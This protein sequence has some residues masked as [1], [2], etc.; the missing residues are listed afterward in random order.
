M[1]YSQTV[2]FLYGLQQ[3]G[4][5]LGLDT[6]KALL[7][8]VGDP[9]RR[10]P[11][12]HIGGTNGK[13]S[14]SAMV[15]AIAQAAG[16]RVGLYTSPHLI[17]Y[18]ERMRVNG[19]MISESRVI[20]LVEQLRSA[21]APDLAPTFFEFTTAM[22]CMHFAEAGIDLAVLEV[23][24]GGRF[25]ATNVVTPAATAITT[26]GLDHEQYL[27]STLEQIAFEKAGI[28]KPGSPLVLGRVGEA[29]GRVIE[30]R[31]RAVGA[32]VSRLDREFRTIGESTAAFTYEGP[33]GRYDRLSCSLNG[34]FNWTMRLARFPYAGSSGRPASRYPIRRSVRDCG[35]WHGRGDSKQ[36]HP[37]RR[38]FWMAPITRLPPKPWLATLPPGGQEGRMAVCAW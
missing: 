6:I 4:I 25:D 13:G 24:L 18:R 33:A 3:H 16:H 36:R 35:M 19:E 26:I 1:T 30:E 2:Q 14:T 12:V 37:A 31:A 11:V 15:A 22:A 38:L 20:A 21:A 7:G 32:P 8:R 5:K 23:G 28:I 27:G 17:D 29:A 10:Y 34:G 9:Q